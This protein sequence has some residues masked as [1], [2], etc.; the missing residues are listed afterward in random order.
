MS[1]YTMKL[2]KCPAC[3]GPVDPPSGQ[4]SMKCPYCSNAIVIPESLR[5]KEKTTESQSVFSGIEYTS[6]VGYGKQWGEVVSLAQSGNKDEAIK[7]YVALTGQSESD[8]KYTVDALSSSQS[9]SYNQ[10]G[11]VYQVYPDMMKDAM[12]MSKSYMKWSLWLGCGITAFVMI[13][14][15]L[16]MLP[17]I[18]GVFAS[19]WAAFN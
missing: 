7:K 8:A 14:I 12:N 4:S 9:Y 13:I 6:M 19:I 1:D 16:T 2:L 3:G 5:T 15:L 18:I 17:I 11:G 10:S